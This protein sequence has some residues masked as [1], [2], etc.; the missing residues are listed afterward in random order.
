MGNS[1]NRDNLG[2]IFHISLQKHVVTPELTQKN[3]S[4]TRPHF[5]FFV[6]VVVAFHKL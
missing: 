3:G 6:V 4:N 5:F 2:I 1:G